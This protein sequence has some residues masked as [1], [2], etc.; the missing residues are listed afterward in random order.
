MYNSK[1]FKDP[2]CFKPERFLKD[3][4]FVHD[5]KVCS[6]SVGKRNCIGQQLAK[7]EYFHFSANIILNFDMTLESGKKKNI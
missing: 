5:H 7:L 3:G 4:V 6:F 1:N 2:E